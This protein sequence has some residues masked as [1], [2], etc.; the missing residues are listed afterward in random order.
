MAGFFAAVHVLRDL[1]LQFKWTSHQFLLHFHDIVLNANINLVALGRLTACQKFRRAFSWCFYLFPKLFSRIF[2]LILLVLISWSIRLYKNLTILP[3]Y[4]SHSLLW[5]R[6]PLKWWWHLLWF[7]FTL[8]IYL[9]TSCLMCSKFIFI[10][11]WL[12]ELTV[13]LFSFSILL[14]HVIYHPMMASINQSRT[15]V[16]V[17]GRKRT[18]R[19]ST[20]HA[21]VPLRVLACPCGCVAPRNEYIFY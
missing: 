18:F 6:D 12:N 14:Y 2:R 9:P 5:N 8:P 19:N 7:F 4:L 13:G 11:S 17:R 1:I 21:F 20:L 15:L 10:F 16:S 3:F